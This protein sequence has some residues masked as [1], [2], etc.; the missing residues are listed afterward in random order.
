[1]RP[2]SARRGNESPR[3]TEE[4]T[5]G[6]TIPPPPPG[7]NG[8]RENP[9]VSL[10]YTRGYI[11]RPHL[12]PFRAELLSR[13]QRITIHEP[14]FATHDL[15][16]Y[17]WWYRAAVAA[18]PPERATAPARGPVRPLQER[19]RPPFACSPVHAKA[20]MAAIPEYIAADAASSDPKAMSSLPRSFGSRQP[21]RA[22]K[23]SAPAP[24][25]SANGASSS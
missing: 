2:D 23:R 15:A 7:R 13:S 22:S 17:R 9:R 8:E 20:G 12:G 4:G 18:A 6:E 19:A 16:R 25:G 11:P 21:C 24:P 1:M 14:R 10:C 5:A 3:T